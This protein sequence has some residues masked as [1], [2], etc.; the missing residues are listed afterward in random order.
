M[1]LFKP[2]STADYIGALFLMIVFFIGVIVFWKTGITTPPKN[3]TQDPPIRPIV[4]CSPDYLSY[5][6]LVTEKPNQI[7]KPI[8][9][10]TSMHAANGK[11]VNSTIIITKGD[12][13]DSKVACG[14]LYVKVGTNDGALKSWEHVYIDPNEFGGHINSEGQ[15]GPGDGRNASEYLFSLDQIKYWKDLIA[16]GQKRISNADWAA[17]L[18]VSKQVSFDV[19]LSTE[20]TTGFVEEIS[21]AYKCWNPKTGEENTGCKL[22]KI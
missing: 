10:K 1:N 7:V 6:S 15:I 20:D 5:S 21:I 14:Y 9:K 17:L 19:G 4:S 2:N 13:T 16:I 18:N 8:D 11:F 12:T 3:I 22:E